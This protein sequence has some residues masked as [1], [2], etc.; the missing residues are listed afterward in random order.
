MMLANLL[1]SK[2]GDKSWMLDTLST[3]SQGN[4]KYFAKDYI[5]PKRQKVN[6]QQPIHINNSDNFFTGLP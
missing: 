4:H 5:A 2:T 1:E 6:S 3:L